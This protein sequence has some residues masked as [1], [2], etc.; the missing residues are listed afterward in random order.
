M[1]RRHALSARM[2]REKVLQ[3]CLFLVNEDRRRCRV[4][5][6]TF[7]FCQ[8]D[9]NNS[10]EK[11][12]RSG[13]QGNKKIVTLSLVN[14]PVSKVC[15]EKLVSPIFFKPPPL[16]PHHPLNTICIWT[17]LISTWDLPYH[18]PPLNVHIYSLFHLLL[19][20]FGQKESK[21]EE[22]NKHKLR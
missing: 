22:E 2:T 6:D 5:D 20:P 7:C 14:C 12:R 3:R 1:T 4:I 16:N 15:L 8:N 17:T 19:L 13:R 18:P 11:M 9:N 10:T 21:K